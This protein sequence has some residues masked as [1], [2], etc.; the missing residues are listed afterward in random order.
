M[1]PSKRSTGQSSD[2]PSTAPKPPRR[3]GGTR[4]AK[5]STPRRAATGASTPPQADTTVLESWVAP[6]TASAID[7]VEIDRI[8]AGWEPERTGQAPLEATVAAIDAV[9]VVEPVLLRPRPEGRYEVVTGHR[10]VAA[11]RWAGMQRVPA[12]VKELDDVGAL[13]AL[14]FDGSA[15]GRV[16]ADGAA[17]LRRRLSAA[18]A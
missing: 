12:I 1:P 18:G 14:V 10:T 6:T 4:E 8:D 13:M 9:G 3:S 5:S 7:Q 11:A 16:T 15:T 2:E 17:D